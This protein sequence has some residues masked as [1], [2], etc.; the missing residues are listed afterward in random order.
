MDSSLD[1]YKPR[2]AADAA[3]PERSRRGRRSPPDNPTFI[4]RLCVPLIAPPRLSNVATEGVFCR[5]AKGQDVNVVLDAADDHGLASE[6]L[7][8][9]TEIRMRV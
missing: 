6:G 2:V 5:P 1:G 8:G 3:C 4:G 9:A 7:G